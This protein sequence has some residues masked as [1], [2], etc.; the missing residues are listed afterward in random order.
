MKKLF[1]LLFSRLFMITL[2][3]LLQVALIITF[4]FYLNENYT[5]YQ[6]VSIFTSIILVFFIINRDNNPSTK[7]PWIVTVLLM[8][9][10]GGL[11]YILFGSV[12]VSYFIKK[13]HNKLIAETSRYYPKCDNLIFEISQK[14]HIVSKQS[15]Y[16]YNSANM[17][18]YKNT[19]TEYFSLGEDFFDALIHEMEKAKK[20]IF[21]E[22]F[23]V[24]EGK[25]WNTI[26]DVMERKVK[27]GVEVRM[28]YDDLGS[29]STLPTGYCKKLKEKGIKCTVFNPYRATVSVSLQNRD[30]RKITIID[31]HTA[32]TGGCNLA[33]EYIN[34]VERFGHWKD[35]AI[36]LKGPGVW[37]LTMLFLQSWNF[38]N[39]TDSNYLNYKR[40]DDKMPEIKNA[41]GYVQPYGDS[42]FNPE[43]ISEYVYLNFINSASRYL[44]ITTPYLIVDNEMVTSL[45]LAAKSG[46][47]VRIITP[48]IP[49]KWYVHMISQAYYQTLLKFGV[50]VFEYKPGFIHSKI[51]V[52][53]DMQAIVGTIN[54]DF[55]SLYHHFECGVF[56]YDTETV[57]QVKKDFL[58]TQT[59]CIEI[60][61][62]D[63]KNIPIH[64]R[65]LRGFLKFFA[66]LM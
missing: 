52:S 35:T 32:F 3:I 19:S 55:R 6:A 46:V 15:E 57:P 24:E 22:Y 26:L 27:E 13:R 53:D 21:M 64:K 48:H 11:F 8:P 54:F 38:F 36:M 47:D 60:T 37:N 5:Y 40:P 44:Y 4:L 23:I 16:I 51:A 33:D 56:M 9:L 63:C 7:I 66:P 43:L 2:L 17:P 29:I 39:K 12:N 49:D 58:D 45:I 10:V 41:K 14:N 25:M 31:G 42:P 1:K 28:M 61:L 18:V 20:F 34:E 30:H 65:V 59:K 50:R 62:E